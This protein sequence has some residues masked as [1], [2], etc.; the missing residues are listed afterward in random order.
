MER[1]AAGRRYQA[2]V[3]PIGVYSYIVSG[4]VLFSCFD[5]LRTPSAWYAAACCV[6]AVNHSAIVQTANPEIVADLCA[7][8]GVLLPTAY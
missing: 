1:S 4:A 5:V 8:D 6:Y 7:A 3:A 2:M